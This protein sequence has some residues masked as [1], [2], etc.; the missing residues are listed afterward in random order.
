[1]SVEARNSEAKSVLAPE[2]RNGDYKPSIV[3]TGEAAMRI[4]AAAV[5]LLFLLPV[6]LDAQ[7]LGRPRVGGRGPTGPQP[8]PPQP[9][10]IARQNAFRR[11]RISVESYPLLSYTMAPPISNNPLMK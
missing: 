5:T 10:P 7:I 6:V 8:L 1:M 11:L 2:A 3:Y 4:R 9:G